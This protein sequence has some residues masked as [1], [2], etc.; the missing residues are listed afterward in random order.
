MADNLDDGLQKGLNDLDHAADLA[1]RELQDMAAKLGRP[2]DA[3][4]IDTTPSNQEKTASAKLKSGI[5]AGA[6]ALGTAAGAVS[7][8]SRNI[9]AGGDAFEEMETLVD[10][11]VDTLGEL[12]ES[13]SKMADTLRLFTGAAK[14]LNHTLTEQKQTWQELSKFGASG[15]QGLRDIQRQYLTSELDIKVFGQAVGSASE[16]LA[17]FRGTV[18]QGTDDFADMMQTLNQGDMTMRRLGMDQDEIVASTT[19][20]LDITSRTGRARTM[21]TQ[22][23]TEGAKNY[24]LQLDTLARLTGESRDAIGKQ[25]QEDLSR[26]DRLLAVM[27]KSGDDATNVQAIYTAIK[28]QLGDKAA[29]GFLDM[30]AGAAGTESAQYYR[31][32]YGSKTDYKSVQAAMVGMQASLQT[33]IDRSRSNAVALGDGADYGADFAKQQAFLAKDLSKME[34][35]ANNQADSL[36]GK[37]KQTERTL[38][39]EREMQH[40]QMLYNKELTK[41]LPVFADVSNKT[42]DGMRWL[43]DQV[44]NLGPTVEKVTGMKL[45]TLEQAYE[46]AKSTIGNMAA[47]GSAILDQ[48]KSMIGKTESSDRSELIG[49]LNEYSGT[50]MKD[51]VGDTYAWCA[52]Y[53]NATL[54]KLGI[55]GTHSASAASFKTFGESVWDK[56]RGGDLSGVKAGDIIVVERS[57]GSGSHVA[58]VQSIDQTTGKIKIVGGNQGGARAGGGGVT[59]SSV[60]LSEVQAIRR[61]PGAEHMTQVQPP[62]PPSPVEVSTVN[63]QREQLGKIVPYVD[64]KLAAAEPEQAVTQS[65]ATPPTSKQTVV[66]PLPEEPKT[67]SNNVTPID[68][69]PIMTAQP[70]VE[71]VRSESVAS[72]LTI[73]NTVTTQTPQAS[74]QLTKNTEAMS[75]QAPQQPSFDETIV[76]LQSV[77]SRLDVLRQTTERNL[78]STNDARRKAKV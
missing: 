36:S 4:S 35:A 51:V 75:T 45:P 6:A 28:S 50:Q 15:A 49:Y 7:D 21:S 65:A 11:A 31:T 71:P 70:S 44:V 17:I 66:S 73:P 23:M 77:S 9:E 22:Q 61:A 12:G 55:E 76:L 63:V 69:K 16:S 57:G 24:A 64:K 41:F 25:Q 40:M 13:A 33:T 43:S 53:V 10:G 30:R 20:Y 1:N 78:T 26:N 27:H 39:S 52:R 8:F 14:V 56:S 2:V 18:S 60:S 59:E 34:V 67:E 48:A 72:D 54:G 38:D 29:E 47:S 5:R 3:G 32:L 74:E 62:T 37:D 19:A 58:F 42:A 46:G 68:V